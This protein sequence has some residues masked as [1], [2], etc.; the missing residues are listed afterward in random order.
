MSRLGYIAIAVVTFLACLGFLAPA[1]VVEDA[2]ERVPG[3]TLD[4]V[5]G[6]LWSGTGQLSF[7]RRPLGLLTYGFK[8]LDVVVLRFSYDVRLE[9]ADTTLDGSASATFG[10]LIVDLGGR[11]DA[12]AL[13]EL[14]M[15]YD[16]AIGGVFETDGLHIRRSWDEALPNV[17]GELRWNGAPVSYRLGQTT[18]H[19]VLPALSGFIDSSSGQPE[20]TAYEADHDTP[21]MLARVAADGWVTIGITKRFTQLLGQ[22]WTGSDADHAVVLE[23]QEQLF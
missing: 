23:V 8:P 5:R 7:E 18:H 3:V 20:M 14:L 16:M 1:S 15:R 13:R 11:V 19:V 10:G 22:P 12:A 17:K 21:L 9:S 6:T 2:V 4:D